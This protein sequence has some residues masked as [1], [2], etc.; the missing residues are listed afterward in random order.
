MTGEKTFYE[1]IKIE[2]LQNIF[3]VIIR[4]GFYSENSGNRS[5]SFTICLSC[6]QK[7]GT[8]RLIQI[9]NIQSSIFNFI[10]SACP[11]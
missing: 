7:S 10:V 5:N 4:C 9:E 8:K 1:A 3:R 2:D 6:I 11:G